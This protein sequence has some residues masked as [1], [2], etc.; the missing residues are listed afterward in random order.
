[1]RRDEL[2]RST[3]STLAHSVDPEDNYS[4]LI[5]NSVI[6]V[7][8]KTCSPISKMLLVNIEDANSRERLIGLLTLPTG[9]MVERLSANGGRNEMVHNEVSSG[10]MC[11]DKRAVQATWAS[12]ARAE[13]LF[14]VQTRAEP[15]KHGTY[16]CNHAIRRP[17]VL[18]RTCQREMGSTPASV[19]G[20]GQMHA[21]MHAKTS[22]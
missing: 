20:F 13:M 3:L 12:R 1:M 19:I 15:S 6:L 14:H 7:V 11:L 21:C 2:H 10:N 8:F 18:L 22:L 9:V 17:Y 16:I 4:G 5:V